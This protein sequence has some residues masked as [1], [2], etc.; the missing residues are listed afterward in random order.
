[1]NYEEEYQYKLAQEYNTYP[2]EIR[3][4]AISLDNEIEKLTRLYYSLIDVKEYLILHNDY[5][6]TDFEDMPYIKEKQYFDNKIKVLTKELEK[7][8]MSGQMY[9]IKHDKKFK[10][11]FGEK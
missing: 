5:Y 8:R 7:T 4:K 10:E 11:I 1:M 2:K 6:Y 3:D 9:G